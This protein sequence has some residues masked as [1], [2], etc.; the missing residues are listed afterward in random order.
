MALPVLICLARVADVTIG[1]VRIIS[2]SRRMK[3]MAT[4]LGFFEVTIWLFAIG[5]VMN[6]LSSI[7]H[8]IGFAG[9][10]AIGNYLG[11]ALEEKLSLGYLMLR[12]VTPPEHEALT[13]ALQAAGYGVTSVNGHGLFNPVDVL[14]TVI[15]R[16][17]YKRAA[18]IVMQHCPE[19][20][21]TVEEIRSISREP[22][23]LPQTRSYP[24]HRPPLTTDTIPR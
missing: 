3:L 20:F 1:T 8:Y 16:R 9:G 22:L 14:F 12:V 4:V 23:P 21:F 17:D 15:K 18:G 5:Q 24:F 6:N 7:S 19:A 10:F 13:R 11:I 2:V